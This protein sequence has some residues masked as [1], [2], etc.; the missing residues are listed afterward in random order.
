MQFTGYS[1][2][3]S[4]VV[5]DVPASSK[6]INFEFAGF[7][8]GDSVTFIYNGSP[9]TYGTV[10]SS[11]NC[12]LDRNLGATAVCTTST[13]AA[14]YGDLYQWGRGADGHQLRT[15]GT[16]TTLSNSDTPGH[17]D[18]ILA[19]NSPHDWRSPHNDN[20]WQGVNGTNNP[21]PNGWRIPT[22][23]EWHAELLSWSSNDAWGAFMSS[24]KLPMTGYR[25][26]GNGSLNHVGSVGYYWT[27]IVSTQIASH[28]FF[29]NS[30]AYISSSLYRALGVS[31]RCIKD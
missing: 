28:L 30:T 22:Y 11:G 19:P 31:V 10:L 7:T 24:L 21:C 23:A 12:W 2:S 25:N 29:T 5:F 26:H 20:L 15:S 6:T 18:F 17:N 13:H 27:S 16:T 8:C 14:C 4:D 9:V 1:G 3:L